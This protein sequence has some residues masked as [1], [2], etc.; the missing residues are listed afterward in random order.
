MSD[1]IHCS[2]PTAGWGEGRRSLRGGVG[3]WALEETLHPQRRQVWLSCHGRLHKLH[4]RIRQVPP[5]R[6]EN[7][8]WKEEHML[9]FWKFVYN[10]FANYYLF[11]IFAIK[12]FQNKS[13][14]SLNRIV[15]VG[16]WLLRQQLVKRCD[17]SV[18][19]VRVTQRRYRTVVLTSVT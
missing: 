17:L 10:Q 18:L 9:L 12:Y 7:I 16:I 5:D 3:L 8:P 14:K 19:L 13:V 15:V 1:F 11:F 4:Q 2:D 6:W